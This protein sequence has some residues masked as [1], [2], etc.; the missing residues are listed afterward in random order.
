VL[1]RQIDL[2]VCDYPAPFGGQG[3]NNPASVFWPQKEVCLCANVTYN[4]WPEQQKDVAFQII[5]P[6]G[7]TYAILC[8]RTDEDGVVRI[9]FRLPWMCDDPEYYFGEWTVIATVDVACIHINDTMNFKYDYQGRIWKVTTDKTAYDHGECIEVTVEYGSAAMIE[10]NMTIAVSGLDE[11]GVPFDYEIAFVTMGGAEYC[12]YENGTITL[13]ICIPKW[14]RA[15]RATI[16]VNLLWLG[17]PIDGATQQ[18]PLVTAD[19]S[20][21]AA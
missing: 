12:T 1:G 16:H 9:C 18:F 4:L 20:I 5:D 3:P 13:I 10:Y 7:E 11:T 17:L 8:N 19:I 2:Y 6:Y 14:A 15:G 21:N